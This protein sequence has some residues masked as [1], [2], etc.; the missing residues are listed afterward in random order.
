MDEQGSTVIGGLQRRR[1]DRFRSSR[2][3][4]A[5]GVP[6]SQVDGLVEG[7]AHYA[8]GAETISPHVREV[9]SADP[10]QMREFAK[11]CEPSSARKG[12]RFAVGGASVPLIYLR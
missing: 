2:R 5:A 4:E 8:R 11:D 7:Y 3:D 12:K 10:R 6:T 9:T 1:S